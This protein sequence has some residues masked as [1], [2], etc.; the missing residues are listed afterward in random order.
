MS[1]SMHRDNATNHIKHKLITC[2]G[3]DCFSPSIFLIT[4]SLKINAGICTAAS[5]IF[6]YFFHYLLANSLVLGCRL[7]WDRIANI[8]QSFFLSLLLLVLLWLQPPLFIIIFFSL[9]TVWRI[10]RIA[11]HLIHS[12]LNFAC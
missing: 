12:S 3:C 4:P 10:C 7:Q 1:P 11:N 6:Y 5:A 2:C 9:F 8:F